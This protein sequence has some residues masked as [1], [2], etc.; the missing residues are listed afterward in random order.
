MKKKKKK[1]KKKLT[2]QL[3]EINNNK[4]ITVERKDSEKI[5]GRNQPI[6]AK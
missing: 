5:P 1:K 3:E 2:I 6:Q 4:K